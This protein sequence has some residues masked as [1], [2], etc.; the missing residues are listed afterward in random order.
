[1]KQDAASTIVRVEAVTCAFEPSP[2]A[3]AAE[4][5]GAIEA[6]WARLVAARPRLFDGRVL[7]LHRGD[8]QAGPAGGLVFRGAFREVAFKAFLAWRDFG[9][10]DPSVRNCF[11]MAALRGSDGAFVLGEMG[12]H[13]ANAGRIYFPSGTPDPSDV[14][15]ATVDIE[16]SARRELEEE[17]GLDAAALRF[18]P[19]FTL[20]HDPLRVC[21]MKAVRA[22]EP[23]A[24]LVERIHAALA[25]EAEPEL[26]RMHVVR[27]DADLGPQVPSFVAAYIRHVLAEEA[28]GRAGAAP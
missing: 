17:T 12:A 5:A 10:P 11:A 6:H 25:R 27:Q 4:R 22:T 20:V 8:V 9:H 23:A 2:W 15:G 14:A 24:V 19:G 3:F 21:C 7:L 28:A 16:G 26:A 13:T 1:M 18:E